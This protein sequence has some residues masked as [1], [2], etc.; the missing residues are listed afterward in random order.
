MCMSRLSSFGVGQ[1]SIWKPLG[2]RVHEMNLQPASAGANMCMSR[3]SSFGVDQS[4]IWKVKYTSLR[5]SW[6]LCLAADWNSV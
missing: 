6:L 1:S 2:L 5:G 3:L 4:S